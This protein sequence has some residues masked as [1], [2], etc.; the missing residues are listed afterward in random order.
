[1]PDADETRQAH[2]KRD[3]EVL[4]IIGGF[5]ALLA[6]LVLIGVVWHDRGRGLAVGLGAGILLL[7]IGL[8]AIAIGLRFRR[9]SR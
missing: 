5:F 4:T 9:R 7:A 2:R 3:A 8:G 1:M 6:L